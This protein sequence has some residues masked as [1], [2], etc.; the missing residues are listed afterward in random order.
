MKNINIEWKHYNKEGETCAR[1]NNTGDNIKKARK[2]ISE[3]N[4][5]LDI[6]YK[7]TKLGAEEMSKSNSVLINGEPIEGILNAKKSENYCHSCTCLAGKGTNCRTVE[8]EGKT[9]EDLSTYM[10]TE[11]IK[12]VADRST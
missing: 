5:G 12:I 9:H 4:L 8:Y 7:E 1:C 3:S 11:A 2:E 10:I 6:S